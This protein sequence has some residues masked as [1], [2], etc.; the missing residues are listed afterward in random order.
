VVEKGREFALGRTETIRNR[1]AVQKLF[2]DVVK[3][4]EHEILLIFPTVNSFLREQRLGIIPLLKI[5]ALER[6][7]NIR[8][9]TPINND[10]QK[11]VQAILEEGE[12][13][14][15]RIFFYEL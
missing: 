14:S 2:I 4:A 15:R 12:S 1:N 10:V 3:S 7:I 13:K 11:I 6:G 5:G 9:L 8:I